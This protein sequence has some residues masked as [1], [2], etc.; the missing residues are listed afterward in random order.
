M[1]FGYHVEKAVGFAICS[2]DAVHAWPDHDWASFF[3]RG[4]GMLYAYVAG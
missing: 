4:D 2:L 3:T 1:I